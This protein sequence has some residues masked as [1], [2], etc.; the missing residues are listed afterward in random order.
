MRTYESPT[1]H[2][3]GFFADFTG[4]I[5]GKLSEPL[6]SFQLLPAAL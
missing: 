5:T 1:L 3:V 4:L 6:S 2:R